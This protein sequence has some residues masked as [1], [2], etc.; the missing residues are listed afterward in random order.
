MTGVFR[1][2]SIPIKPSC[3]KSEESGSTPSS[4]VPRVALG[5][6]A[7]PS[8]GPHVGEPQPASLPKCSTTCV[9][10][11]SLRPSGATTSRPVMRR[12][13]TSNR[14]E[15]S[16]MT[17][18]FPRR[19]TRTIR[20]PETAR[21]NRTPGCAT[22]MRASRISAR[23]IVFPTILPARPRTIV[24]TSGSS[25]TIMRARALRADRALRRAQCRRAPLHRHAAR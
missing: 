11:S 24:S 25:G 23:E 16:S 22:A 2:D 7:H 5:D 9:P 14:P 4:W 20:S 15:A 19:R 10:G 21:A 8:E 1:P 18:Y 13:V 3:V 6:E 12:L 17:A